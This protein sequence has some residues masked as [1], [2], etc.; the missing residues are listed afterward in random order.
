[1]PTTRPP[2]PASSYIV[3]HIQTS[4]SRSLFYIVFCGDQLRSSPHDDFQNKAPMF[5]EHST[6]TM[7]EAILA[8]V[9]LDAELREGWGGKGGEDQDTALSLGQL[10][11][12]PS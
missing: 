4:T 1:M 6:V 12:A 8:S 9:H 7:K 10:N 3:L 5:A 2:S 11:F